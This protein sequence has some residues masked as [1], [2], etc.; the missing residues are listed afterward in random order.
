M[1]SLRHRHRLPRDSL[2]TGLYANHSTITV[3]PA[4]P[5][6][7]V[8]GIH[9]PPSLIGYYPGNYLRDSGRYSRIRLVIIINIIIIIDWTAEVCVRI[10]ERSVQY[11]GRFAN[12][13]RVYS[14]L[15]FNYAHY[16]IVYFKNAN[17]LRHTSCVFFST[18]SVINHTANLMKTNIGPLAV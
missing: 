1:A 12:R 9:T 6:S 14:F 2:C 11:T 5:C 17:T 16:Y 18:I 8:V 13:A 15:S 10:V 4:I 3:L 7:R